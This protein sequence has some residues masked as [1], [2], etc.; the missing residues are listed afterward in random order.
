MVIQELQSGQ[1]IP[2]IEV[3]NW[4]SSGSSEG[5]Y[6][7][8]YK[9]PQQKKQKSSPNNNH[10]PVPTTV[11]P[12]SPL[13]TPSCLKYNQNEMTITVK[14]SPSSPGTNIN[15]QE[16]VNNVT[17]TTP[18]SASN[19]V[20]DTESEAIICSPQIMMFNIKPEP[21]DD[22]EDE[23]VEGEEDDQEMGMLDEVDMEQLGI[24]MEIVEDENYEQ[25]LLAQDRNGNRLPPPL[26]IPLQSTNRQVRQLV[27]DD[28]Q[29]H[30][31][32]IRDGKL[33]QFIMNCR[34][35]SKPPPNFPP[36]ILRNPRGNQTRT[37]TTDNLWSALMDV[38]SGESIYRASQQHKVPRKTLRNWMKR[39]CIKSA[40]PMPSQ[41]K[42]AAEKKKLQKY[43][44]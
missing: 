44:Y 6:V 35:D 43:T 1:P 2:N 36:F 18:T 12:P 40:Y 8:S 38:K 22:E 37:Y 33:E 30:K 25:T 4:D 21:I 28:S 20:K 23:E 11:T 15:Q 29:E 14:S 27:A 7:E 10:R 32:Y 24:K 42:E 19:P 39:C 17:P 26:L 41:L 9:P 5:E 16:V 31:S 34:P 13:P 3:E